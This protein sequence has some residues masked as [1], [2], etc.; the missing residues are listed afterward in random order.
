MLRGRFPA[1]RTGLKPPSKARCNVVSCSV[2]LPISACRGRRHTKQARPSTEPAGSK[3]PKVRGYSEDGRT[4][5]RMLDEARSAEVITM[6]RL[7]RPTLLARRGICRRYD[8]PPR[9]PH[10]LETND[11]PEEA[12]T[13]NGLQPSHARERR[14]EVD[15]RDLCKDDRWS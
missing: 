14:E 7:H 2:A 5:P 4:Y 15:R 13:Q 3:T 6:A 10:R 9:G 1:S 12:T 11:G 8:Q